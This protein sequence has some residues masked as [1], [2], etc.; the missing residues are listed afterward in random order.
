MLAN[1]LEIDHSCK[2]LAENLAAFCP[3]PK[4]L[5]EAKLKSLGLMALAKEISKQADPDCV[6]WLLVITLMQISIMEK[7][8]WHKRKYKT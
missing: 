6:V 1:G 2:I 5:P 3:C 4:I 7:N 8:N